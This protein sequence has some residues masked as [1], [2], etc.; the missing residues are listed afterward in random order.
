VTEP[1]TLT[2]FETKQEE[3]YIYRLAVVILARFQQTFN[4]FDTFNLFLFCWTE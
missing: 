2:F 4:R 3:I 1:S